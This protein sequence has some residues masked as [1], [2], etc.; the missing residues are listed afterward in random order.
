MAEKST[1]TCIDYREEMLLLS[2]QRRLHQKDLS[3]SE[4]EKLL[5]EI[6]KIEL[7]MQLSD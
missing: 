2:L 4:K 3:E 5:E 7:L 6:K 1:Y